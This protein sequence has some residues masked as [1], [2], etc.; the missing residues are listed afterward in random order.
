MFM[1]IW[2]LKIVLMIS[3]TRF[4]NGIFNLVIKGSFVKLFDHETYFCCINV[5]NRI[6]KKSENT[7]TF[8]F[9]FLFANLSKSVTIVK[10]YCV[11]LW[12]FV[13]IL[14][15]RYF[16]FYVFLRSKKVLLLLFFVLNETKMEM[17]FFFNFVWTRSRWLY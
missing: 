11:F 1:M 10:P 16:K 5:E 3:K 9:L 12:L 17:S 7:K 14:F 8:F 2:K 13:S 4:K 6:I 15:F